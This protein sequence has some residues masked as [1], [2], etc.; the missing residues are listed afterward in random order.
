MV[1]THGSGVV[2][3]LVPVM[4]WVLEGLAS[5]R[6]QLREREEEAEREKMEREE[7]ME[8]YQSERTLRRESQEVR[9]YHHRDIT[10]TSIQ[11]NS[12]QLYR[13]LYSAK[14]IELSQGALQ[15]LVPGHYSD[16]T[17]I[18]QRHYSDEDK[19]LH[20]DIT[21]LAVVIIQEGVN[22]TL[23]QFEVK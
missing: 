14:T 5:C 8:R 12:I 11:F 3:S 18:L 19:K 16:V 13:Y 2:E 10:E 23:D 20:A 1:E 6:A 21:S 17:V 22:K 4:V 15:S 9:G 7:L